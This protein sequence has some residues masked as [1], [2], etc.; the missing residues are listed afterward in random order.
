MT[1]VQLAAKAGIGQSALSSL[2][3]DDS[4]A[5]HAGTLLRLAAA[6]E[7]DPYWL[8][9]GGGVPDVRVVDSDLAAAISA[10]SAANRQTVLVIVRAMLADQPAPAPVP[11]PR[12]ATRADP[13]PSAPVPG[14]RAKKPVG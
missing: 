13:F 9:T 1:Q 14:R 5:P 7:V 8:Q 6:L 10:L 12:R 2:E 3:T 11:G 4:R